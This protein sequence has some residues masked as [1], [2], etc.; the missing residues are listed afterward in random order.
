[1]RNPQHPELAVVMVSDRWAGEY[2]L[3][4]NLSERGGNS[5]RL[6]PL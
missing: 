1:M 3:S 4:T 5:T 6:N 2:Q